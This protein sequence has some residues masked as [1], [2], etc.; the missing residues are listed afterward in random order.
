MLRI[1]LLGVLR[2]DVDGVEVAPPS[3]RRARLLLAMLALERRSHS[4]ETLAV[5]LWPGVLDES[6]RASLR[7]ALAQ[8]R[9]A[10]G[11]N[12]SRFLKA[13]RERVELAGPEEVWTDVG[14][15]ERLLAAGEIQAPLA[16]WCG[17][18]LTGLEDDWVYERRDE[19]RERL[20]EAI[21]QAA[22][23][24]E[25]GGDLQ[26]ALLLTRRQVGLDALAEESQRELI[27]RLACV[28]DRAAALAAYDRFSVRLREQLRTVPS[29]ATRELVAAV[30]AGAGP[31]ERWDTL[32]GSGR[33]SAASRPADRATVRRAGVALPLPRPLRVPVSTPFVGRD[34]EL[35]CLR[36][37]WMQ[38]GGGA[39]VAVVVA[40]EAGIGKTRLAAE[41][42]GVAYGEGAL[43]LYGRCDEGLAVP[44]QPFVQALRPFAR[45][46]GLDDL[47]A[48]L[49]WLAPELGRVLP[50]LAALGEPLRADP[51]SERFALFEAVAA[52]IEAATHEQRAL[53]VLDDLHWATLPTLLLLRHLIRSERPL[54]ALL[55]C[56]YRENELDLGQSLAQ[57]L[58]DLH[59]D[60]SVHLLSI[61]GLDEPAIAAL[62]QAAVGQ[63]LD[64][65]ASQLV[66]VLGT[67]TAGNPFFIRELLAHVV[68]S[69]II[70]PGSERSS[71]G[72]A[73][74]EVPEELRQVIG[75]RVARL[76]APARRVLS[77]AAVAGPTFSFAL[78]DRVLGERPGVL[79]ALDQAVAARFL[80]EAGQGEYVFAHA[81]VRQTIYRELGS[82]RR[83]RL[84][85]QLGEALETL[86]D[87][88]AH[89][90]ALAYHFAQAAADGQGVKAADYA[91]AAGRSAIARLGYE[92]AAAHY[93]RGLEALTLT[94]RPDDER[95]RELLLA[96][97]EA[98]WDAGE[99]DKARRACRQAADLAEQLG[100]A[101]ALARAALGFCGPYR[102]EVPVVV[103]RP[104][105]LLERALDA[106]DEDDS[107]LRAQLLGRLAAAR[108]FAG[109][110]DRSPALAGRALQMA[111]RVADK[112]T[113]ADVLASSLWAT[114]GPDVLHESVALAEELGRVAGE[115]GDGRLQALAHE[116]LLDHLLELGDIDGVERELQALQRLADERRERYVHWVLMV[117]RAN[118]AHLQ[119]RLDDCEALARDALAHRFEA[120][121]ESAAQIFG[122]QMFFIRSAQGRLD[123]VVEVIEGLAAQYPGL[124]NWRCGLAH[125]YAL[126]KRSAQARQALEALASDD[127]GDLPRDGSW[128][129]NLSAL[130]EAVVLLGDASRARLL[131]K[132]L[133]PYADRC[134]VTF[135]LL[136]HGSTSRP[137]G[138]LAATLSRYEDAE[139]H[140]EQAI[141]MN[142]QIR[143]PL[144][145]VTTQRDYARMLLSRNR[146]G[147]N[148]KA[149]ELLKQALATADQLGLKALANKTL[150]LKLR[151]QTGELSGNIVDELT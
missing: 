136:C 68:E 87:A 21:G 111:R 112:A 127:F 82:A 122:V 107:T 67:Q 114:H 63:G 100:D 16:S 59:R 20:C 47:R 42:A 70:V 108:A 45:A 37:R 27:R 18:L 25:A 57:M 96:L 103:P 128:L 8:L 85:R 99:L 33:D 48:E 88:D 135:G 24:A 86:G 131:Y 66:C 51:E 60:S 52:L 46:V 23:E 56:T 83:T 38:A 39:R 26:T 81:L 116:R 117:L 105:A 12:A 126:V 44:Y 90:E 89:I 62:V 58:A 123:E 28:G 32:D 121:D 77:V 14:E 84:H 92:E 17:E 106:L 91:L 49:G 31:D 19:L 50:E 124:A 64:E 2:L 22:A 148:D 6:A 65:R 79:D 134:A 119:G 29:A 75:Q 146:A 10:L 115:V 132:L 137:L 142:V 36:E 93:E 5:R 7:T 1:S 129:S 76:S 133:L 3:S 54:G 144:W 97:G 11:P 150:P 147:D 35:E 141:K 104:V 69:D 43:V 61:G 4:R 80:T 138:L 95:R 102:V 74:L 109:D 120:H 130:S 9:A 34:A 40:G 101:T 30:R 140:F 13:T 53:L 113:L 98:H 125:I 15:L 139:R 55:L 78:L 41:L 145:I 149:L 71:P 72:L 118:H 73:E 151:T 94:K 110:Q 143:A